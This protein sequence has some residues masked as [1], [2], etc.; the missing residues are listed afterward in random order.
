MHHKRARVEEVPVPVSFKVVVRGGER[1]QELFGVPADY[2][3]A[4]AKTAAKEWIDQ[5]RGPLA[6]LTA[7]ENPIPHPPQARTGGPPMPG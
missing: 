2:I 1:V 4:E 5:G 3:R 6:M 7:A